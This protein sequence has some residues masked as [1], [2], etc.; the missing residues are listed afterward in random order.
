MPVAS[1]NSSIIHTN[2][3]FQYRNY[4]LFSDNI[5]NN[6]DSD[7]IVGVGGPDIIN[8]PAGVY[9]PHGKMN[10]FYQ[11]LLDNISIIPPIHAT[12]LSPTNNINV[13]C[14]EINPNG[15][16][17]CGK[18]ILCNSNNQ[19]NNLTHNPNYQNNNLSTLSP[20]HLQYSPFNTQNNNLNMVSKPN[21]PQQS[22]L[23]THLTSQTQPN[24]AKNTTQ[25]HRNYPE[26]IQ[27]LP[28]RVP[29]PNHNVSNTAHTNNNPAHTTMGYSEPPKRPL[30]TIIE[31]DSPYAPPSTSPH[32]NVPFNTKS[33]SPS[34]KLP[35]S[36]VQSQNTQNSIS[37]LSLV[38]TTT[39]TTSTSPLKRPFQEPEPTISLF[40][41]DLVIPTMETTVTDTDHINHLIA[42]G[43]QINHLGDIDIN[44][45][46]A[47]GKQLA[48]GG[49]LQDDDCNGENFSSIGLNLN[50][51]TMNIDTPM[52]IDLTHSNHHFHET[53]REEKL[54]IMLND[55]T[56]N[57]RQE[58]QF[59]SVLPSGLSP[60]PA[61]SNV[62]SPAA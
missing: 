41:L 30:M 40:N 21:P 52:G 19:H 44:R 62:Q 1:S 37:S 11:A 18:S 4:L 60:S 26:Q 24:Q 58:Y 22:S 34:L 9:L 55:N 10:T 14:M 39:T 31:K 50:T 2:V 25:Q 17:F 49:F 53:Q 42:G 16:T 38:T 51:N 32:P 54:E 5:D 43:H 29:K 59:N 23:L 56:T 36:S 6:T 45:M 20:N 8:S 48:L 13:N 35:S 12:V 7:D 57:I 46:I 28:K 27:N 61:H 47:F 15:D 3:P 33:M